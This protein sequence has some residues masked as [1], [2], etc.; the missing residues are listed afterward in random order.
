MQNDHQDFL[1]VISSK[2]GSIIIVAYFS[3]QPSRRWAHTWLLVLLTWLH[4][5]FIVNN[6]GVGGLIFPLK[7]LSLSL[8]TDKQT[9]FQCI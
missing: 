8:V 3:F 6:D 1:L 2:N 5:I 9:P 7:F 4:Q